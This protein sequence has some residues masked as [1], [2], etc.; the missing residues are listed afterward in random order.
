MT[1]QSMSYELDQA[2]LAITLVDFQSSRAKPNADLGRA[3][4]VDG[5]VGD[6][7][8]DAAGADNPVAISRQNCGCLT[9]TAVS[10]GAN[11]RN[12]RHFPII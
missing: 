7:R 3:P 4:G 2:R 10:Q 5:P 6:D 11:G 8:R 9:L 1:D 12:I